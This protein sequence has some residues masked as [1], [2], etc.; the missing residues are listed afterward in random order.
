MRILVT[1]GAGFIGSHLCDRLLADGGTVV[2]LDNL[3]TGSRKNL[4]HLEGNS[5]FEFTECDVAKPFDVRGPFDHVWH[6]ASLASPKEYLAHPIET[7]E[8]GSTATR[9]MLEIARR[10]GF[11]VGTP[12]EYDGSQYEHQVP[13]A[14]V[15]NLMHQLKKVGQEKHFEAALEET[16]AWY[17][18]RRDWWEPIKSGEY[19]GYYERMYGER[20]AQR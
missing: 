3:I 20:L 15:S 8:S 16:V 7:L 18:D 12:V 13:G 6:L 2:A 14:M 5:R 4:A 19:R 17:A 10:E 1:G 11:A 9:L